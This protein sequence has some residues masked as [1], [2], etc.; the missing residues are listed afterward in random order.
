MTERD[1]FPW[2]FDQYQRYAVLAAAVDVLFAGKAVRL[3]DVGG[4]SPTRDGKNHWLPVKQ[5]YPDRNWGLDRIFWQ[6][7]GYIQGDGLQLPFADGAF[8][9][10]SAMDVLEHIPPEDRS[11]FMEELFRVSTGPVFLSVPA[12]SRDLEE[13]EGLLSDLI[14]ETHGA[15]HQQLLEHRTLGLPG[16]EEIKRV[17]E[18]Q[19]TAW[20]RLSFGSVNDW[21]YFQT[22]RVLL[23]GKR[24]S[25]DILQLL[26]KWIVSQPIQWKSAGPFSNDFWIA[27]GSRS[28]GELD[29]ALEE[30]KARLSDLRRPDFSTG[31]MKELCFEMSRFEEDLG[32][33]A[34]LVSDAG[35]SIL[36]ESLNHVLTQDV[37]EDL[38]VLVWRLPGS[39]RLGAGFR[40]DFPG[41]QFF[42]AEKPVSL[43]TSLG[44][45]F[46][47]IRCSF[48]LLLSDDIL[49]PSGVLAGM[50]ERFQA[51]PSCRVLSPRV[52][53][54]K[55]CYGVWL[56]GKFSFLK[57][58]AGRLSNPFWQLK[59]KAGG[60][61][62]SECLFFQKG[63]WFEGR[64]RA[65]A[66][67]KRDVFFWEAGEKES[68][69][70]YFSDIFVYRK[71]R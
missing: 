52:I 18:N 46:Q 14:E 20:V 70:R 44:N 35:E 65:K 39:E 51:D 10:L 57:P 71:Q 15:V 2:T 6:G 47:R 66:S 64:R 48:I 8:D 63:V 16:K 33:A 42:E 21:L 28:Q 5:Y 55:H 13:A 7:G 58:A 45:C 29:Q 37:E 30:I 3:L 12:R 59:K 61:I 19:G 69:I 53:G 4:L 40:K 67:S 68:G 50:R 27:D 11:R 31:E 23:S 32:T 24:R 43:N 41:V 9:A 34:L 60:W 36:R 38:Q 56:G 49:L 17:F 1:T 22:Q 62:Y 54:K 26:D 25:E